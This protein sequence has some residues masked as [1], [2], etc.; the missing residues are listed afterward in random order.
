MEMEFCRRVRIQKVRGEEEDL[1]PANTEK[2]G[3]ERHEPEVGNRY[4]L[5]Q[6][7][8]KVFRTGVVQRL[9]GSGFDT[10]NSRYDLDI[11]PLP[12]AETPNGWKDASIPMQEVS[13]LQAGSN[14]QCRP[15]RVKVRCADGSTVVG[16]VNLSCEAVGFDRVSEIF[17]EG[18]KPFIV[19]F[20]AVARGKGEMVMIIN[21]SHIVWVSPEE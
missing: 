11:L 16:F 2:E 3:W 6:D 18:E 21:K 19:V 17:T 12:R 7:N 14:P 5:F 4:F 1:F 10:E 8:G 20:N 15:A 9:D 13:E